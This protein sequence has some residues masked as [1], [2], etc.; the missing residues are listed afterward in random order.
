M[1]LTLNEFG[2]PSDMLLWK[3]V[4]LTAVSFGVGL[5]GGFVG[6]AL[7]TIRLPTM[8]L[9]GMAAP[10]AGGTNILVSSL[11]SLTGAIRHFREG[12]VDMR[13]RGAVHGCARVRGA[14][15]FAGGF[16]SDVVIGRA[17]AGSEDRPANPGG[18]AG[19]LAGRGVLHHGRA[20]LIMARNRR[21]SAGGS[22]H[23]FGADLEGGPVCPGVFSR[24][25]ANRIHAA[26]AA[27]YRIGL[28][29]GLLGGAGVGLILGSIRL[30]AQEVDEEED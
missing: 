20:S 15:A 9:L 26:E 17:A 3:V 25:T 11:A 6:L 8:L 30:P 19:G 7:G 29:V 27:L 18:P 10:I 24:C 5:L 4:L 13:V 21:R 12:R 1:D 28:G 23:L 2:L 14:E 22:Q 16:A